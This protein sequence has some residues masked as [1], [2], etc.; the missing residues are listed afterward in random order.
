MAHFYSAKKEGTA[1]P[2]SKITKVDTNLHKA[3]DSICKI[4]YD[5][6]SGTGFLIKLFKGENPLFCLMTCAHVITEDMIKDNKSVEVSY[7]CGKKKINICL[8]IRER[9]IKSYIYLNIDVVVI[10]ILKND[11][12]DI[13]KDFFLSA[14]Q[15][16]RNEIFTKK[17]I[18][19]LQYPE[20]RDLCYSTDEIESTENFEFIHKGDTAQGSSGSPAFLLNSLKELKVIGI[21]FGKG[22][23]TE[24]YGNFIWPI[25]ESLKLNLEYGEKKYDNDKYQGELKNGKPEGFGK[26]TWGN[27]KC[28]IGQWKNGKKEG[29]GAKYNMSTLPGN[30]IKY[31]MTYDGYF[32]NDKYDGEGK[33]IWTNGEYYIGQWSKGE[34]N[35]KGIDYYK[36]GTIRYD[37]DFVN[38]KYQGNGKYILKNGEYYIGQFLNGVRHGKGQLFYKNNN[39]KYEGEFVN[40]DLE[41]EGKYYYENDEYYDGHW[42]RG[43]KNGKGTFYYK[44]KLIKYE[45]DFVNDKLEGKGKYVYKNGE[46]YIGE[47]KN[48]KRNGKGTEFY[49]DGTI[50]CQGNFINDCFSN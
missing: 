11:G 44:N 39:I 12:D 36:D 13:Y 2:L 48:D 32:V 31:F 49:R 16:Y 5:G 9:F 46:Y 3:L 17:M 38:G 1:D 27:N 28:Y 34:R 37:G 20:S 42:K 45:G 6:N 14:D 47:W 10:E 40:D 25:S 29:K 22:N 50:K 4:V 33:Y 21:H 19:I 26:Y 23:K 30:I 24:K 35:G 41:G 7:S 8:N 15:Q 18:V 43:K